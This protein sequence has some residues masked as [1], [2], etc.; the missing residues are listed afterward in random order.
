ML[1]QRDLGYPADLYLEGSDQH[2]GWFQLSLL[3][4]LGA[5]NQ[6]PFKAVLTHGFM[7]DKDGRKMSKSG[8]NALEVDTL[9]KDFG[10]DVCR[11]WVGSLNA[12]NDIK[13]DHDFFRVAG[14]EYRKVRNTIRYLLSNLSDFDPD[15]DRYPFSETDAA[16]V[17]AWALDN[18]NQLI[19]RVRNAYEGFQFRRVRDAIFHFCNETMSATYLAATKDR[20]YCDPKKGTRRRRTQTAIYDI[21]DALI[22]LVAPILPYTSDEAWHA[23][24]GPDAQNV[25]LT[26]LPSPAGELEVDADWHSLMQIKDEALKAIESARAG[27]NIDNPLDCGLTINTPRESKDG[28]DL[29][30]FDTV[31]LAD[32]CGVSRV[33]VTIVETSATGVTFEITDLR[34][35]PRCQRCW[36][37]DGTV[38]KRSDGGMLSQR[39]AVALGL[40]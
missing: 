11:W 33:D 27:R 19:E 2:R 16:S 22:R 5:T 12:D 1:R 29:T 25:H 6:S 31:D 38:K 30:R 37:R 8:G 34:D 23:L 32:L 35:E 39:D 20:L 28:P 21:V 14:E 15:Q 9:L 24:H 40:S 13:V 17:D 26:L 10:A 3:P 7:V 4:A 18:L 36:K